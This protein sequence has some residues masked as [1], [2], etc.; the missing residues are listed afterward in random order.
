M[1]KIFLVPLIAFFLAFPVNSLAQVK[2]LDHR[3]DFG[4][5]KEEEGPREGF[6]RV[7]NNGEKPVYINNVITTCGCTSVARSDEA[8]APGDTARIIFKYNPEG[9]PGKFDK[10][11]KVFISGESQPQRLMFNG[12]VEAS[13]KTLDRRFPINKDPLR[14]ENDFLK[15]GDLTKGSRRHSFI[16]IYNTGPDTISPVFSSHEKGMEVNL[17]PK[18]IPPYEIG[19]LSIYIHTEDMEEG[20]KEFPIVGKFKK[21][22]GT[23]ENFELKVSFILGGPQEELTF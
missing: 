6:F 17:M 23:E 1:K 15:L 2:W 3:Y 9:R 10:N 18:N 4:K 20:F 12:V 14:L 11:L 21:N 8:I 22:D 13:E 7:V 19:S 5:I 16:G